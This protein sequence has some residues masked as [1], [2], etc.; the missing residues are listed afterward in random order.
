[1]KK[2]WFVLF[3]ISAIVA[4]NKASQFTIDRYY[5]ALCHYFEDNQSERSH[6][7][8]VLIYKHL[9][10]IDQR[11]VYKEAQSMAI[12]LPRPTKT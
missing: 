10:S 5:A 8:L 6:N 2:M 7:N 4:T 11:Q 1:M 12:E 9:D 3:L